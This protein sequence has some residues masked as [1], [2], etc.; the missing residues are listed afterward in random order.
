MHFDAVLFVRFSARTS[1]EFRCL[2]VSA[3]AAAAASGAAAA[4][5]VACCSLEAAAL[6]T[7]ASCLRVRAATVFT[8]LALRAS[9]S[10]SGPVLLSRLGWEGE[11]CLRCTV[12]LVA[13]V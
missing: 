8:Y 11:G 9:S 3:A 13:L 5:V 1:L 12:C 2:L 6:L 7:A 4:S 10:V